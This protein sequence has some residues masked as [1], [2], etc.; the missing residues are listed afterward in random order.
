MTMRR[1]GFTLIELLVSLAVLGII[2]IFLT[3]MLIQQNRA[4]T[5]VEQVTDVQG[6]ARAILD[7]L[8]RDIRGTGKATAEAGVICGVDNTGSPDVLY[9]TDG[10]VYKWSRDKGPKEYDEAGAVVEQPAFQATGQSNTIKLST[11]AADEFPS[12][13]LDADGTPDADFRPGGA[14]IVAEKYNPEDGVACGVILANGVDVAAKT[15]TVNFDDP[16]APN[17]AIGNGAFVY[18]ATRYTVNGDNELVRD[19]AVLAEDVEDLQVSYFFDT[20]PDGVKADPAELPG[21]LDGVVYEADDWDNSELREIRLGIVVRSRTPDPHLP[22]AVPQA[23]ENRAQVLVADGYRRR[24]LQ[25]VMRPRNVG[26]RPRPVE[27]IF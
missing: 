9:V 1:R 11:L 4:Y 15:I 14:V 2:S 8:E 21:T 5:V 19:Q 10:S 13:D 23:L 20:T 24:V 16:G 25:A 7:L 17:P 6:N 12:H 27:D 22:N 18:P 3:Q 26:S